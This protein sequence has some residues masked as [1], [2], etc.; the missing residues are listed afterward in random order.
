MDDTIR[1]L[2]RSVGLVKAWAQAQLPNGRTLAEMFTLEGLPLWDVVAV[3]LARLH[4]PKALSQGRRSSSFTQRARPYLSWA[5]QTSLGLIRRQRSSQGCVKWPPKSVFLF[6]GFSAY[7]YRDV[8][9]PVVARLAESTEIR[10]VS[11]HDGQQGRTNAWLSEGDRFQSIWQHWDNETE[12]KASVLRRALKKAIVEL[13]TTGMLPRIIQDQGWLLWPHMRDVFDWFFR[14]YLPLLLPQAS[15][16]WHI[17]ERHRPAL[18]ISPDVADPRTRLYCLFGR[19]LGIPT[20]EIQFGMCGEDSIEW[21]FSEAD[22]LAVWGEMAR[23]VLLAHGVPTEKITI[24]GSPRH[25]GLVKVSDAEVARTRARLGVPEK[26]AMVLLAS[27]YQLKAYDKFSDP[28]LLRLMKRAVFQAVDQVAG[29][30]LVVKPHPLEDVR[31]TK[32]LARKRRNIL[33]VDPRADICKLIKVSDAFV[34]LGSSATLDALISNKLTICPAF[35]GWIWSDLFVKSGATLVPRSAEDVVRS[36]QIVVDCSCTRVLVDL[37]PARQR[38]LSQ[39][40]YQADGRASVRI[41]TLARQMAKI[42]QRVG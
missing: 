7:I 10:T 31:E 2:H 34:G 33:F 30:C 17:L 18:V 28:E 29:V 41:E 35:P 9:Q 11:L 21:Q 40:V 38:F 5:K 39:W 26:S 20:L 1:T 15:I 16:A 8:L 36:L 3:D 23:D 37:E 6:L 24:T 4:V 19:Q 32:Q 14:V 22:Q 12:A 27:A 42:A 25:D 13:R